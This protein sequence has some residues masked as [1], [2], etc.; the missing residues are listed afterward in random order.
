[1]KSIKSIYN[2]PELNQLT[3]FIYEYDH[4][5]AKTVWMQIARDINAPRK[6]S[7][8]DD[9][10]DCWN[11]LIKY[12]HGYEGEYDL[13]KCICLMGRT[14]A[15]KTSTMRIFNE[16]VNIDDVMYRRGNLIL[17]LKFQIVSARSIVADYQTGGY[18]AIEKYMIYPNLLIDDLGSEQ[19]E[20]A[21]Y[22]GTKLSVMKEV[23]EQ[24]DMKNL[25]T[26]Y[27]TNLVEE[28]IQL[29]YGDR[30]YSRIK[31]NCN[32]IELNDVDFRL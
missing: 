2:K 26:H 29:T 27:T 28:D 18:E 6:L 31:G 7:L 5:V 25:M 17:R 22:F 4:D 13:K 24:R 11:S 32:M 10:R 23:I 30:I 14:G 19:K 9:L 12:I 20:E 3:R 21:N 16:Y 1:M 15:G 8:G